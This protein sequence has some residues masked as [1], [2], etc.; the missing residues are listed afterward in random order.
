MV[1]LPAAAWLIW[2]WNELRY[3][4]PVE[5]RIRKSS[6]KHP[7]GNMGLPILG[8]LLTFLWYFKALR[9]ADDCIN[10]KRQ[11]TY[12]FGIPSIITHTLATNK[13]IFQS[14]VAFPYRWPPNDHVGPKSIIS[15]PPHE[16]TQAQEIHHHRDHP[17]ALYKIA[18]LIQPRII[19]SLRSWSDRKDIT[20]VDEVKQMTFQYIGKLF[21]SVEPG[22]LLDEVSSLF[23]GLMLG[24]GDQP[25]SLPG[26]AYPY[27]LQIEDEDGNKLNDDEVVDNIVSLVIGGYESISRACA[28]AFYYLA[29]YPDVLHKLREENEACSKNEVGEPITSEDVAKMKY[30]SKIPSLPLF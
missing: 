21:A 30:T 19:T 23:D 9:R 7:P 10:S 8:K 5:A 16:H 25:F 26:T 3:V 11:R 14:D 18:L 17:R 28:W 24:F 12:L 27:A 29:S 22:P 1:V 15:A 20:A 13:F 6:K 4:M 2:W